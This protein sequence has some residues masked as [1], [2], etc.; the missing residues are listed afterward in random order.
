MFKMVKKGTEFYNCAIKENTKMKEKG[1]TK[2]WQKA[3]KA[4]GKKLP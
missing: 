1:E 2:T 3:L 4:C